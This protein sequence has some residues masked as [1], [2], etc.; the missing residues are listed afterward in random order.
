MPNSL[1]GT[2]KSFIEGGRT[3]SISKSKPVVIKAYKVIVKNKTCPTKWTLFFQ[4]I[5]LHHE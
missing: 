4:K 5:L 2:A 1:N 3:R